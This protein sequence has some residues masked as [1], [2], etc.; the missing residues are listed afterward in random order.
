M[1]QIGRN[2]HNMS[3]RTIYLAGPME[4]VTSTE[5]KGWRNIATSLL[6]DSANVLDPTR[7]L[8][9]FEKKYMRRIFELDLRDIRESDLILAN[10]DNPKVAKHGTSMEVFYAAYVLRIPVIAFKQD[11]ETIHPFF[12]SLVTEWR[13]TV[14]K[15]CD[16]IISEYL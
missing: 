8:H 1:N 5:A 10:L 2:S 15:A 3:K 13:S 9:S 14:E 12:E 6:E 4:H 11:A 16:T 7:R